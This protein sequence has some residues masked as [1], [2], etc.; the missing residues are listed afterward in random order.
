M[1]RR[2]LSVLLACTLITGILAG[3]SGNSNTS[4]TS[5]EKA[6]EEES[7]QRR[8]LLKKQMREKTEM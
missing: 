6:D 5:T 7:K 3:C 8:K 1:K 2:I 4:T